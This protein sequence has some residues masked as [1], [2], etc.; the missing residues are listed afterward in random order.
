MSM[1]IASTGGAGGRLP[2]PCVG[3]FVR[4]APVGCLL[5]DGVFV[6]AGAPVGDFVRGAPVGCLLR[7]GASAGSGCVSDVGDFAR[8]VRMRCS[9]VGVRGR[10]PVG[11][12]ARVVSTIGSG[13][14]AAGAGLAPGG[15]SNRTTISS[16]RRPTCTRARRRP[17]ST[18]AGSAMPSRSGT[19]AATGEP[20][21]I[22]MT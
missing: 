5:R 13:L 21:K 15:R 17:I 6:R 19:I 3:D 2:S 10:E 14:R 20:R 4:G 16:P 9:P 22:D 8:G 1:L 7:R 12:R 18:S 11:V